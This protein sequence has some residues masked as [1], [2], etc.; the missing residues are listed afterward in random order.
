MAQWSFCAKRI[1]CR[2][3]PSFSF[4]F[5]SPMNLLVFLYFPLPI[6]AINVFWKCNIDVCSI[7]RNLKFEILFH[8]LLWG[9]VE[10][11]TNICGL[12]KICCILSIFCFMLFIKIGMFFYMTLETVIRLDRSDRLPYAHFLIFSLFQLKKV[13]FSII[14]VDCIHC[15]IKY[16]I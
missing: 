6:L 1:S 8:K 12:A 2:N 5:K 11:M 10:I 4:I 7:A 15:S 3:E 9:K 16:C 14:I 13:G